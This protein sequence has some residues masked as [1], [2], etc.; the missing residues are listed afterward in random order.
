MCGGAILARIIPT[1]PARRVTAAHVWPAG[2][3]EK[4]RKVGGGG[5]F[6]FDDDFEAAFRRFDR[7]DSEGEEDEVA[8][9]YGH[10]KMAVSRRDQAPGRRARPSKYW[11]VR[12]RPWGKWAAEIRDP[13][14]GVRVWLGTFATAEAAAHAYDAAARD[15]RGANAKL[16]FP[17]SSAATTPRARKRRPTTATKA[18]PNN[19]VNLIDEDVDGAHALPITANENSA[20]ES[21]GAATSNALPDFTWQGLSASDDGDVE[22]P[23]LDADTDHA[24]ELVAGSK[25]R[26]R[27]EADEVLSAPLVVNNAAAGLLL[28]DDPFLFGD[29]NGD[30]FASLMAGQF[31]GDAAGQ[32]NVAGESTALWSFGD[33][34]LVGANACY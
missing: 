6:G 25:K 2:E 10:G 27:A 13:V 31:G 34:C 23:A 15:L 29:F 30:T 4:R 5:S 24:T 7:G 19:V 9:E 21:S 33:D 11:G 3:G 22:Q 1:T 18:A 14:E 8:R 17:S 12:R 20:S 16:N 28:F 26:L 32:V